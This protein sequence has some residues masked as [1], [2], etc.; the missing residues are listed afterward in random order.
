MK[1]D[2]IQSWIH[3]SHLKFTPWKHLDL[4]EMGCQTIPTGPIKNQ[5][6]KGHFNFM[7]LWAAEAHALVQ[8]I[9]TL[10]RTAEG[11]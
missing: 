1:I 7:L 11:V 8:Y 4:S 6:G 2:G 3:H 5:T 10:I 9:R